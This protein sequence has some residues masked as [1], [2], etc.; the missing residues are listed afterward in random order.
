VIGGDSG[1]KEGVMAKP[2]AKRKA[3]VGNL[4]P[5]AVRGAEGRSVKGG[6]SKIAPG[7]GSTP[8]GSTG[9]GIGD[10]LA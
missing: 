8:G 5:K 3:R 7:D 4:K 2:K 1:T 9:G 10:K 6:F